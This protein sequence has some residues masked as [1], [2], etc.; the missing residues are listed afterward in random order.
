MTYI[1]A[2][3]CLFSSWWVSS[4]GLNKPKRQLYAKKKQ[5][6]K[7]ATVA[8]VEGYWRRKSH[9]NN[10]FG[11]FFQRIF[12]SDPR[13][14]YNDH[15]LPPLLKSNLTKLRFF[16]FPLFLC[17]VFDDLFACL[18]SHVKLWSLYG[19]KNSMLYLGVFVKIFSG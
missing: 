13:F 15:M 7:E 8:N 11:E 4:F 5:K 1:E 17:V 10:R 6:K 16:Y 14:Y 12:A 9:R 18:Q 19:K 3:I 2:R